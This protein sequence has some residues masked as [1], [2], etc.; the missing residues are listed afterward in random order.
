[1]QPPP[2]AFAKASAGKA[3]R[4]R[5]PVV[6]PKARSRASSRRYGAKSGRY[7][8]D[9][10]LAA[11]YCCRTSR[12]IVASAASIA[13]P[14][15]ASRASLRR[16]LGGR[17][18]NRVGGGRHRPLPES[19]GQ[20]RAP[21]ALQFSYRQ[22]KSPA[23]WPGNLL[24]E[25]GVRSAAEAAARIRAMAPARGAE[26]QPQARPAPPRPAPARIGRQRPTPSGPRHQPAP[27]PWATCSIMPFSLTAAATPAGLMTDAAIAG[28]LSATA[29]ATTRPEKSI[30]IDWSPFG[31]VTHP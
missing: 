15:P 1:M 14:S 21:Y 9:A 8:Y 25:C 31:F 19:S 26:Q 27:Q 17:H 4:R 13:A 29:A 2:P 7:R 22:K 18:L 12:V 30:R 11:Q 6:A 16:R 23:R 5:V 10:S 20:E 24:I 3:A 28:A